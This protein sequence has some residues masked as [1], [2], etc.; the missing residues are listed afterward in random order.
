M[1]ESESSAASAPA[2]QR[3]SSCRP[4]TWIQTCREPKSVAGP[5]PS[6]RTMA[7]QWHG[8]RVPNERLL[9]GLSNVRK[10]HFLVVVMNLKPRT[11]GR[12]AHWQAWEVVQTVQCHADTG[13]STR[14]AKHKH[15]QVALCVNVRNENGICVN[16]RKEIMVIA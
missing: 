3:H 5:G 13:R 8:V 9:G 4:A 7:A 14:W 10:L 15:Q 2:S 12:A 16:L 11:S 1:S 6:V